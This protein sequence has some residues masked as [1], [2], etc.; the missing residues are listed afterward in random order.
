MTS[1]LTR[2]SGLT[3]RCQCRRTVGSL[4]CGAIRALP[5][6]GAGARRLQ[7]LLAAEL[8]EESLERCA[9]AGVRMGLPVGRIAVRV[10]PSAD[11]RSLSTALSAELL[12]LGLRSRGIRCPANPDQRRR[13]PRRWR[14]T[15]SEA[16]PTMIVLVLRVIP[17][18]PVRAR[19]ALAT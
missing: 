3:E 6:V 10:A 16:M 15:A 7:A 4:S 18:P 2:T 12:E 9:A 1:G 5:R 11:C 19:P 17:K 8:G 14:S 13:E